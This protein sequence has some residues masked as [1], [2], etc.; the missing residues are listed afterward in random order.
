MDTVVT[1]MLYSF[2]HNGCYCNTLQLLLNMHVYR[3]TYRKQQKLSKRTVSWF[4]GFHPN[5][6]LGKLSRLIENLQKAAKIFSR[7]AFAVYGCI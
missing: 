4:T 5:V 7:V 1:V 6:G 3:Y 2:K